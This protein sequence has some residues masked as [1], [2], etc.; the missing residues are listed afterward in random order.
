[1]TREV[2]APGGLIS[3][4]RERDAQRDLKNG[5]RGGDLDVD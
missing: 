3:Q 5:Q 1:M 2:I 4:G